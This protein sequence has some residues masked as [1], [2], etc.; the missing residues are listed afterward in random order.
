MLTSHPISVVEGS[1]N[2][3][4]T[5]T[6]KRAGAAVSLTDKTVT[7]YAHDDDADA[8]TNKVDGE[9]CTLTDAA[10]GVMTYTFTA[11]DLTLA[12]GTTDLKGWWRAKIVDGADIEWTKRETFIIERNEM[13]A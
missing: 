11:A 8:G 13:V 4:Y 7:F 1:A 6:V 5:I 3:V 10:N 12:A 2:L 9:S